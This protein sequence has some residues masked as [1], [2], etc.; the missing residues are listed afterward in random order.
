MDRQDKRSDATPP[1]PE[2]R[3]LSG[4]ALTAAQSPNLETLLQAILQHALDATGFTGAAILLLDYEGRQ[5]TPAAVGG[6]LSSLEA[7]PVSCLEDAGYEWH[8]LNSNVPLYIDDTGDPSAEVPSIYIDRRQFGACAML[9]LAVQSGALG[10]LLLGTPIPTGLGPDQRASLESIAAMA[11]TALDC[12][13]LHGELEAFRGIGGQILQEIAELVILEDERGQIRFASPQL[14]ALTGLL[15]EEVVGQ[16]VDVLFEPEEAERVRQQVASGVASLQTYLKRLGGGHCPVQVSVRLI[17]GGTYRKVLAVYADLTAQLRQRERMRVLSEAAVTAQRA[18]SER[19]ILTEAGWALK[20]LGLLLEV[21][22]YRS[23][24]TLT[25]R[26]TSLDDEQKARVRALTGTDVEHFIAH[27]VGRQ[28]LSHP[29]GWQHGK[30]YYVEDVVGMLTD[31]VGSA[32]TRPVAAHVLAALGISRLILCP[33]LSPSGVTGALVICGDESLTPDDLPGISTFAGQISATLEKVRLHEATQRQADQLRTVMQI[34]YEL[35][36]YQELESLLRRALQRLPEVLPCD[37]AA[38][39]LVE[40]SKMLIHTEA[41]DGEPD[42]SSAEP[43]HMRLRRGG[44][45]GWVAA[46]NQPF[47]AP[48][49]T[50]SPRS[51]SDLGLPTARCELAVPL[52]YKGTV[53]GV[54]DLQSKQPGAYAE[55]DIDVLNALAGQLAAAIQ[56]IRLLTEAQRRAQEVSSLMAASEAIS[57]TLSLGK[58]LELLAERARRLVKADHASIYLLQD[59]GETLQALVALDAHAEQV[60]LAPLMVGEG[61]AGRVVLAGSGEIVND[62]ADQPDSAGLVPGAPDGQKCLLGVPLRVKGHVF[63]TMILGRYGERAFHDD[64]LRLMSSLATQAA[65]AIEN[66]RLFEESNRQRQ[67]AET[68]SAVSRAVGSSLDPDEVLEAVVTALKDVIHFDSAS[69]FLFEDS[70]LSLALSHGLSEET[71]QEAANIQWELVPTT[72]QLMAQHQPLVIP[73]TR[74]YDGWTSAKGG[75]YI[76]SWIGVPIISQTRMIGVLCV[77]SAQ[78]NA[79]APRH[80][81]MMMAFANQIAVA[82]DNARLFQQTQSRELEARALYDINKIMVS[83][84]DPH[85]I[86]PQVLAKLHDII[87]YDVG[88]VLTQAQDGE[89]ADLRVTFNTPTP[90]GAAV[91]EQAEGRIIDAYTA[92]SSSLVNRRA[93]Q[94]DLSG[95]AAAEAGEIEALPARLT[96]PMLVGDQMLGLIELSSASPDAFDERDLR[97]LFVIA[98]QMGVVLENAYLVTKLQAHVEHLERAYHELS[99]ANRLKDELVQ[100]VSHELRTPLTFIRGYVELMQ[101]GDLGPLTQ[102]QAEALELICT[103]TDSLVTLVNDIV[104]L[105]RIEPAT[106]ELVAVDMAELLGRARNDARVAVE[107]RGLEITLDVPP[108]P[109]MVRVDARRIQQ[110][111]DN[112][113]GNALKFTQS[114]GQINLRLLDLGTRVRVEVEDSGIGVAPEIQQD[115][116]KPFVRDRRLGGA[117]L[118][119]SISKE[120]VEAHG[121]TIGVDSQPDRGSLFY[122]ELDKVAG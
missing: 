47:L 36:T 3:A 4:M 66:A 121:G 85:T 119:L 84:L 73:D 70:R 60:Q 57:F 78:P 120:I 56:N 6:D 18:A 110:V 79:Y 44:I 55:G 93:I 20:S 52:C 75:E 42:L 95:V 72:R 43:I 77:D 14:T 98:N 113:V 46:N 117:G 40:G 100:N 12:D 50:D 24:D 59:D 107:S 91:L 7:L 5:L 61:L 2:L 62:A 22:E 29:P 34:G 112:L 83:T 39:A 74:H 104:A 65:L 82:I 86:I 23:Q 108:Q 11:A 103:K 48:D 33:M 102:D 58:R 114:G 35:A 89:E 53:I 105:K 63:G 38:I 32:G 71:I 13:R 111:I 90:V 54:L 37:F 67:L 41:W 8:V 49:L 99:E 122:F 17:E 87:G 31:M 109:Q 94:R 19:E 27:F 116:F 115:I 69:I 28:S 64:D 101:E 80:G 81:E 9:P 21:L 30:A 15:P 26:Y 97:T 25:I 88:A 118:G 92:L 16:P 10:L 68:L 1:S 106:L 51:T 45:I 96:V 76:R